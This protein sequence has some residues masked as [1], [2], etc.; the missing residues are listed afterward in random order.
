MWPLYIIGLALI[1]II[2]YVSYNDKESPRKLKTIT[3]KNK[4]YR[5]CQRCF[6]EVKESKEE[7]MSYC[8]TCGQKLHPMRTFF[9]VGTL[10]KN[11]G[12]WYNGYGQFVGNIKTQYNFCKNSDLPMPYDPRVIKHISVVASLKDL[13]EWFPKEDIKKLKEHGYTVLMYE[14]NQYFYKNNHWLINKDAKLINKDV[15]VYD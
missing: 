14:T 10:N 11:E 6:S 15:K 4:S 3:I 8:P 7:V 9:R 13:Y 5:V 2:V 1:G 12:L